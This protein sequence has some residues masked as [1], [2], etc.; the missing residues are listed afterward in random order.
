MPNKLKDPY[1]HKF[2][3]TQYKTTNSK[4]YNQALK[5]RGS[6][7]IW[8]SE[9]AI[10]QWKAQVL[11]KK[12]RGGQQD[13]SDFA[14]TSCLILGLVFK[15]RLRQT[16]GL[17]Q[18]LLK[19]MSLGL[20]TPTYSTISVRSKGLETPAFIKRSSEA[21]A[22]AIDST[23][24]KIYGEQEWQA[25][26][27]SLKTRKSWRKLHLAIDEDGYVLSSSLT[28]HN[29]SDSS[30]LPKLLEQIES[31][32]DTVLA[33]GAYDQPSTYEALINHQESFGNGVRIKAAIPPNLGFR[34]E[35]QNDSNLRKDN[36]RII[37]QGRQR[38]QDYTDYG[39]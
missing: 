9:D 16:E 25:E 17:V 20:K 30:M 10:S 3:K 14:I 24:L 32:I 31:P 1:R 8:F 5:N 15:Q 4:E 2:N 7:T 18:S 27:Y 35:M 13:Y 34:A 21:A 38:W 26:K 39:R 22:T 12:K 37:E 36:I 33:D 6:L 19:L 11:L 29:V 23:G 28:L